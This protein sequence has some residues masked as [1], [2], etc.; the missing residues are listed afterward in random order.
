MNTTNLNP[1][2]PANLHTMKNILKGAKKLMNVV[3][4]GNYQTGNIDPTSIDGGDPDQRLSEAQL[5]V[6]GHMPMHANNGSAM[7][8]PMNAGMSGY[9]SAVKNSR[10]PSA[11]KEA[12]IANPIPQANPY[13]ALNNTFSL[14]DVSDILEEEAPV[15]TNN[16]GAPNFS[17]TNMTANRSNQ[18]VISENQNMIYTGKNT[19]TISEDEL[20]GMMKVMIKSEV[21]KEVARIKKQITEATIQKTIQTLINE[22]KISVKRKPRA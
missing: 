17:R 10:L 20:M 1:L 9:E 19:I 18:Q 11:I 12:M 4:S 7:R 16:A 6:S 2:P 14:D 21:E 8:N 3:E 22:G 5:M 15:R 13:A